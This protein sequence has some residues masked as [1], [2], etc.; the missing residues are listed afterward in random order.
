M[1]IKLSF[2]TPSPSVHHQ[3]IRMGQDGSSG[4]LL[5]SLNISI[6]QNG[7]LNL[8]LGKGPQPS[9]PSVK[10]PTAPLTFLL[11]SFPCGPGTRRMFFNLPNTRSCVVNPTVAMYCP[12]Q[13]CIPCPKCKYTSSGR[14]SLI[15]VGL[16]NFLGSKEASERFRRIESLFLT[17]YVLDPSTTASSAAAARTTPAAGVVRRSASRIYF[18]SFSKAAGEVSRES[19]WISGQ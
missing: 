15:S 18:R 16:G 9:L 10:N 7:Y 19:V 4:L 11:T 13:V 17:W 8:L 14:S 1:G 6:N 5:V 2:I 3:C 12:R